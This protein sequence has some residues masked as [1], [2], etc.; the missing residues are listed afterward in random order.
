MG[1]TSQD[2]G[3]AKKSGFLP[4]MYYDILTISNFLT[5][6]GMTIWSGITRM[7]IRIYSCHFFLFNISISLN[8]FAKIDWSISSGRQRAWGLLEI[9]IKVT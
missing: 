2:G 6:S 7:D 1:G 4:T 9:F 5:W 3:K 8:L